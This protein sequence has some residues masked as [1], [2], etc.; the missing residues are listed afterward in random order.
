MKRTILVLLVVLT[1]SSL[2][3]LAGTIPYPNPGTIAPTQVFKATATGNV[4]GYFY[5]FSAGHTDYVGMLDVT[6]STFSGWLFN[7]QTTVP[8]TSANF[9]S[10]TAGDVLVFKLWDASSGSFY[11]SDPS[12]SDDLINHAYST[13][14][15]GGGGIPAGTFIGMEDLPYGSS[16]LDYNDD[17]FVFVNVGSSTPE[18]STLFMVGTGVVGLA[19]MLRRKI[20][21]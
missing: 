7:N 9:G 21:L 1:A 12:M 18:P 10:V 13:A 11:A 14:F 8:G 5:G 4:T 20:S 15:S 19:G 17:Q 16:D 3:L 6:T 2:A